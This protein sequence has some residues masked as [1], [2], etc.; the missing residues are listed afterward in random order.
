MVLLHQSDQWLQLGL[1]LPVDLLILVVLVGQYL[2][3]GLEYPEYLV[4][5]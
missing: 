3:L 5:L 1:Y 2:Q 4:D